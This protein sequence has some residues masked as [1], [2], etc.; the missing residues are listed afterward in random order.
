MGGPGTVVLDAPP[1]MGDR[2]A[3]TLGEVESLLKKLEARYSRYRADSLISLIN[4]SAGSGRSVALDQESAAL[5]DLAAALW[6]QSGGLFDVTS[7]VLRKIWDFERGRVAN[8]DRL[9]HYRQLVGWD[10]VELTGQSIRLP[11]VGM[12]VDLGGLVK[13]YAA[14]AAMERIRSA[15]FTSALIELAGDVRTLGKQGDGSMWRVGI[16]DPFDSGASLCTVLLSST[17]LASSGG[18]ERQITYQGRRLSHLLDPRAGI[19]VEAPVSVSVLAEQ[20]LVAG[21]IATVATL[22]PLHDAVSW[23]QQA[24]VPWLL[25]DYQGEIYGPLADVI[26]ASSHHCSWA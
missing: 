8:V 11:L 23:L 25:I 3:C 14:D 15:G 5:F 17:A 9:E 26:D 13:E 18:Y 22:K 7:G 16:R 21:A 20:C 6:Q 2:I 4:A 19:P 10:K 12:E 24:D 1:H